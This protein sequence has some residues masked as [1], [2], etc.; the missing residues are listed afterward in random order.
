MADKTR[1]VRAP[2]LYQY[3]RLICSGRLFPFQPQNLTTI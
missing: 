3:R 2:P 1:M